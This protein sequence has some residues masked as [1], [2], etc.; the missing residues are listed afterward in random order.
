MQADRKRTTGRKYIYQSNRVD[1]AVVKEY[2]GPAS[3]PVVNLAYRYSRLQAAR[4]KADSIAKKEAMADRKAIETMMSVVAILARKLPALETLYHKHEQREHIRMTTVGHNNEMTIEEVNL[5]PDRASLSRLIRLVNNDDPSAV[6]QYRNL[7]ND[8]PST[9]A[10]ASS[11]FALAKQ[12]CISSIAGDSTAIRAKL[13]SEFES[14]SAAYLQLSPHQGTPLALL[15]TQLVML[16]RMD[17]MRCFVTAHC[18]SKRSEIAFWSKMFVRS[19]KRFE[20]ALRSLRK[21]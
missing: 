13:E 1:G 10:S 21:R 17:M 2:V 9:L 19:T 15:E 3:D 8:L 6:E 11:L 20:R 4:S 14:D 7:S 12:R 5:L 16:L 18:A